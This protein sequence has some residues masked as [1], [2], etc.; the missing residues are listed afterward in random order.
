MHMTVVTEYAWYL[1]GLDGYIIVHAPHEHIKFLIGVIFD[2]DLH[3]ELKLVKYGRNP[4]QSL[5]TG[6]YPAIANTTN[7][8]FIVSNNSIGLRH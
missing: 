5:Y 2:G 7:H 1:G 3:L 8:T 4:M 6:Y